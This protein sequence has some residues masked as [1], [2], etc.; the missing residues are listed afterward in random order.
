M[1]PSS[2]LGWQCDR[3]KRLSTLYVAGSAQAYNVTA[4]EVWWKYIVILTKSNIYYVSFPRD[5]ICEWS[6]KYKTGRCANILYINMNRTPGHV[7]RHVGLSV[8]G[9]RGFLF[10]VQIVLLKRLLMESVHTIV[11]VTLS[12][13]SKNHKPTSINLFDIGVLNLPEMNDT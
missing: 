4:P 11:Y 5:L 3:T 9:T 8:H 2:T 12:W 1:S 13:F 7:W 10:P 6:T